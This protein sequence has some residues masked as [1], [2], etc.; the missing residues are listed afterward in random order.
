MSIQILYHPIYGINR[1][2]FIIYL[3]NECNYAGAASPS[4]A[5]ALFGGNEKRKEKK[6]D[7]NLILDNEIVSKK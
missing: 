3:W 5:G 2:I 4:A 7:Q 6:K 1:I